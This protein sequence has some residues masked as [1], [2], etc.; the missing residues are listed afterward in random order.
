MSAP[1]SPFDVKTT[2][3]APKFSKAR[4]ARGEALRAISICLDK[5]RRRRSRL[6]A[7]WRSSTTEDHA[8]ASELQLQSTSA[9]G[10]GEVVSARFTGRAPVWGKTLLRYVDGSPVTGSA[11]WAAKELLPPTHTN[12]LRAS[13]RWR[14]KCNFDVKT[15]AKILK[16]WCARGASRHKHMSRQV[17]RGLQIASMGM[18]RTV[19]SSI[20]VDGSPVTGGKRTTHS[21]GAMD[22]LPDPSSAE[23]YFPLHF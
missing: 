1:Y 2:L 12:Q 22:A 10:D 21:P 18:G 23:I 3:N 15:P 11:A 14:K 19:S 5:R 16:A 7:V 6:W 20:D 9:W 8:L 13:E 4:F 17:E